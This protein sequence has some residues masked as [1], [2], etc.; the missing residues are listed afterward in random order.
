MKINVKSKNL[1]LAVLSGVL[2]ILSFPPFKLGFLAW[3][4]LIPI[5]FI[6]KN[7]GYKRAFWYAYFAGVVF[8]GGLLYWL[9]NVTVP[10]AIIL[11]FSLAIFYG[12][13]G[14][15]ACYVFKKS[16]EPLI[17]PFVWVL[18]EYVR[19]HIFTGFPWG[20]LGYTQYTNI[21]LIQIADIAGVY[22]VSFVLVVF[23]IAV[24]S[25]ISRDK[26]RILH[27][28]GALILILAAITYSKY[29]LDNCLAWGSP[30]IAVVQGNIPQE[31]KWD[32]GY[33]DEIIKTYSD[34]TREVSVDRPDMVIWPETAYPY[35]MT[36]TDEA[37]EIAA[38][39][40]E[41]SVPI[42]AGAVSQDGQDYFNSAILFTA[43]G[44]KPE[45]YDKTH[46]VPFG[47]YIPAEEY[48]FSIRD[49]IDKPIGNFVKSNERSLFSLQSTIAMIRPDG[50][51]MRTSNFYKFGVMICFE[52]I[53]PYIARDF[54][55]KGANFLVNMTNDAWFGDTSAL[56][57]HVQASVFRAVENRVSVIRSANTGVS[58]F[59]DFTGKILFRLAREGKDTFIRA[60]EIGTVRVSSTRSFYT[61]N[62]DLFV[63]FCGFMVI[64]ILATEFILAWM[65]ARKKSVNG[66]S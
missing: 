31:A 48:L 21:D 49:Y 38:L 47:E 17:L 23:N 41:T 12:L 33:A 28:V 60:A 32:P 44:K 64:F 5:L 11:M 19:A 4:A 43:D 51:V 15:L 39:V 9:V 63:F 57:Q 3:G 62:G 26:R 58:C 25:H 55:L 6:A 56:E 20:L 45:R 1:L 27:M 16:I 40:T 50:S 66:K 36:S 42:L 61:Q 53:F 30:R 8:F 18:L 29:K 35:L 52:D 13:F 37:N 2:G 65:A 59:I 7:V 46:L 34:L 22:G 10:G 54:T 24:F 14:I